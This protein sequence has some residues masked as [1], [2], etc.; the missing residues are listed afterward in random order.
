[1]GLPS[2]YGVSQAVP[3]WRHRLRQR[4]APLFSAYPVYRGKMRTPKTASRHEAS[5]LGQTRSKREAV[6]S[7]PYTPLKIWAQGRG[8]MWV[9]SRFWK[10]ND[11][12]FFP[13]RGE[14][15]RKIARAPLGDP[16]PFL[17]GLTSQAEIPGAFSSIGDPLSFLHLPPWVRKE[18]KGKREGVGILA[19]DL[20]APAGEALDA[21]GSFPWGEEDPLLSSVLHSF[22]ARPDV[23]PKEVFALRAKLWEALGESLGFYLEEAL[24]T[25]LPSPWTGS[26]GGPFPNVNSLA[27]FLDEKRA[28]L[29]VDLHPRN[30]T[31]L[32]LEDVWE[33]ALLSVSAPLHE[34]IEEKLRYTYLLLVAKNAPPEELALDRLLLWR[35]ALLSWGTIG[36][37]FASLFSNP[38]LTEED[39]LR[40]HQSAMREGLGELGGRR[41]GHSDR[42]LKAFARHPSLGPKASLLLFAEALR[43]G[44]DAPEAEGLMMTAAA[45]LIAG[46]VDRK[47]VEE[48]LALPHPFRNERWLLNEVEAL[49][50]PE[51]TSSSLLEA[52]APLLERNPSHPLAGAFLS[53]YPLEERFFKAHLKA[54]QDLPSVKRRIVQ[55]PHLAPEALSE[56]LS[57]AEPAL[58]AEAS[59][60]PLLPI[61]LVLERLERLSE[62]ERTPLNSFLG[63]V[64]ALQNALI[65]DRLTGD[66][67][68]SA[69]IWVRDVLER[70]PHFK[71]SPRFLEGLSALL[72]GEE[73]RKA[74]IVLKFMSL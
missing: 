62:G 2:P 54:H 13:D 28:D 63:L 49:L 47:G 25:F 22:L 72:G 7:S 36:D 71:A 37:L 20:G 14:A 1:M 38:K 65:A 41:G 35:E 60:N 46:K 56:A 17:E 30:L 66:E 64:S 33:P 3:N 61:E 24:A 52:L 67:A 11:L 73:G 39:L 44:H 53:S 29:L 58:W 57:G 23:T 34:T 26:S 21:V 51:E 42:A 4:L 50:T 45:L 74:D 5:P 18:L 55:N 68:L 59:K 15:M 48:A 69:L 32:T 10:G 27:L 9:S 40:F 8:E 31:S 43:V 19:R 6:F 12:S 70:Y 16:A